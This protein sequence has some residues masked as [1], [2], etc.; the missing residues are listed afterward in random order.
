M[1]SSLQKWKKVQKNG[2]L[3]NLGQKIRVGKNEM[4]LIYFLNQDEIHAMKGS[5]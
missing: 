5:N 2:A 1:E 3:I 4:K